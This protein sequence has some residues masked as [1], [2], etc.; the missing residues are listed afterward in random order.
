MKPVVRILLM[1]IVIAGIALLAGQGRAETDCGCGGVPDASPPS[2]WDDPGA[3]IDDSGSLSSGGAGSGS[4]DTSSDGG[5]AGSGS[6]E[7]GSGS[8]SAG[9]PDSSPS[10][11]A[12]SDA[13]IRLIREGAA[14]MAIGNYTAALDLFNESVRLDPYSVRA[15]SGRGD[16]FAVLG[17]TAE[18]MNAY[19]RAIRLDPSDAGLWSRKGLLQMAMGDFNASVASFDK[20]LAQNPNLDA[21]KRNRTMALERAA[22]IGIAPE[23]SPTVT[24]LESRTTS[25]RSVASE[26]TPVPTR[27]APFSPAAWLAGTALAAAAAGFSARRGRP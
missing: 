10:G 5:S 1:V 24:V 21:V 13:A 22:G 12:S 23:P 16:A 4:S 6:A 7:S 19:D 11:D 25:I 2:G 18:A 27:T 17:M 26:G 15:W 3:T 20:A 14:F 9:S 8:D